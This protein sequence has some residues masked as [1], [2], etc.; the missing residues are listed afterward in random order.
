MKKLI[1]LFLFI[2]IVLQAQNTISVTFQPTDLGLG[3]RYDRMISHIGLYGLVSYGNYSPL[4]AMLKREHIKTSLGLTHYIA[5]RLIG[6]PLPFVSMAGSYH[7]YGAKVAEFG[8]KAV[9][10]ISLDLGAG[11]RFKRIMTGFTIDPLKWE[12]AFNFGINF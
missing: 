10:H 12:G 6:H 5:P 7:Y 4:R 1:F 8:E 2:P 11:V 9:T 3:L